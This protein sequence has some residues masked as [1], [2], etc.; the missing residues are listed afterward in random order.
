MSEY[1]KHTVWLAN[2]QGAESSHQGRYRYLP[3]FSTTR[4]SIEITKE[5]SRAFEPLHVFPYLNHSCFSSK[6]TQWQMGYKH[7]DLKKRVITVTLSEQAQWW[8]RAITNGPRLDVGLWR[9]CKYEVL[10]LV[11]VELSW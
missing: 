9:M 7:T 8:W 3:T 11:I 10:L 4:F 5:D 2:K 6:M 1:T